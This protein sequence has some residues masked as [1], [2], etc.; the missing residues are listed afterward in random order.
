MSSS[1]TVV[2]S[3]NSNRSLK[4]LLMMMK[5]IKECQQQIEYKMQ[6]LLN[7]S[8]QCLD[9]IKEMLMMRKNVQKMMLKYM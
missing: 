8:L 2:L 9:K 7:Q 6:A 5:S 3:Q 1:T 4:S